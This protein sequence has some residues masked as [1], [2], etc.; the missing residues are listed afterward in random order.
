MNFARLTAI[1]VS[2]AACRGGSDSAAHAGHVAADTSRRAAADT[3][4]LVDIDRPTV[5][6]F[7]PPAKD[8]I[9]AEESGY[10]EGVAH[11]G[12]ALEDARTCLGPE[13]STV[14]LVVDTAVRL[15]QTGRIDTLHFSRVDSLSYGAYLLAPGRDELLVHARAPS[16]LNHAV[17][18]S[19]PT[20]FRRP[21]C[22][23]S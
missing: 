9:E 15:R 7:F 4:M 16:A 5:I 21:P 6:G 22:P 20:Y 3:T 13:S 10:S 11:V 12:F 14:V 2:L 23:T 19:L 8:S 1:A 18:E 17:T